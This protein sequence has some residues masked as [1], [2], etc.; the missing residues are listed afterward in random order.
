MPV[1]GWS[2][3]G[4][5]CCGAVR[6]TPRGSA[7]RSAGAGD[8]RGRGGGSGGVGSGRPGVG[9]EAVAMLISFLSAKGSPGV[10]TTVL[11]LGRGGRRR[12]SWWRPTRWA[13]TCSPGRRRRGPGDPHGPGPRGRRAAD[14]GGG[15]AARAAR[16]TRSALPT[17]AGRGGQPGPRPRCRGASSV[18]SSARLPGRHV[19]ADRGRYVP[20]RGRRAAARGDLV[21]L[22]LR[23][24]LP[25]VGRRRGWC[26]CSTVS[27][28]PP[29]ARRWWA[30]SSTRAAPTA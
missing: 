18:P 16:P 11:A 10:T 23:S 25:A 30:C 22:V 15:G 3:S 29:G 13:G 14:R 27:S 12:R 26:R 28:T 24:A 4:R 9:G 7:G 5:R 21:L 19:L 17:T 20:E 1:R 8:G 2:R 6:S